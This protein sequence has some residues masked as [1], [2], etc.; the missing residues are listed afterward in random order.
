VERSAVS[1]LPEFALKD[2]GDKLYFCS[3]TA[4][5]VDALDELERPISID[6]RAGWGSSRGAGIAE[7]E[8]LL[9]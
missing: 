4:R 6:S 9:F 3:L 8:E 2:F 7:V 1:K 5:F